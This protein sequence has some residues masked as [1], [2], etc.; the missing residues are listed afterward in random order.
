MRGRERKGSLSTFEFR[1]PVLAQF[2]DLAP[3]ISRRVVLRRGN[4]KFAELLRYFV[5]F[6]FSGRIAKTHPNFGISSRRE[7]QSHWKS[8][9]QF[10][11]KTLT[12]KA[13]CKHKILRFTIDLMP[14]IQFQRSPDIAISTGLSHG[15]KRLLLHTFGLASGHLARR[16]VPRNSL[17]GRTGRRR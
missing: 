5:H 6:K 15:R 16:I 3:D 12:F 1:I 4:G 17:R 10:S 9:P 11:Q 14:R 13:E 7:T 2:P 8:S